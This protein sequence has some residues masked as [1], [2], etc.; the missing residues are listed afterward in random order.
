MS[1]LLLEVL[2]EEIPAKML[3][4]GTEALVQLVR[5]ELQ[6]VAG[7]AIGDITAYNS[8]RRIAVHCKDITISDRPVEV[9][10]PKINATVQAIEGFAKKYNTD[11]TQ[12]KIVNDTY[13]YS[14][15]LNAAEQ[16]LKIAQALQSV[17]EKFT[18][19]KSMRW[20][21]EIIRWVRPIRS[22]IC[23]MDGKVLP[24]QLGSIKAGNTTKGHM[25]MRNESFVVTDEAAYYALL[26]A[27]YVMADP[28]ERRDAIIA[29]VNKLTAG[30]GLKLRED[31]RLLEEV[32]NLV[33]WP[34]ALL[35]PIPTHFMQLPPEILILTI[36]EH[37]K[38]LLLETEDGSLAPYFIVVANVI[39]Q[40][41]GRS[42]L[43]G[44][45][46]VLQ[47]RLYDASFFYKQDQLIK[48]TDR[49]E[50]LKNIAYHAQIGS[51]FDK[52]VS[53]KR[54]CSELA[55]WFG[56]SPEVATR[57][58]FL[59]KADLTTN[60]VK[61]F[62]ELQGV[63]GYYYALLEGEPLE[64]AKA[65]GEHYKPRGPSDSLPTSNLGRLIS[66]ADKL[67]TIEQLFSINIKPTGSKDPFALRRCAIGVIRIIEAQGLD[68]DKVLSK[69][70]LRAD[71]RDFIL[72]RMK[73]M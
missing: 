50:Q 43:Q 52:I 19:P 54:L 58:C 63:M 68:L 7:A 29:Q 66:L 3:S 21:T 5:H 12:L 39:T 1:T 31:E 25:F 48:L 10:G 9:R 34:I 33:E 38:Y 37:Q 2:S 40:D 30:L 71:V 51:V 62:P 67:D 4:K 46:R 8:P 41:G 72:E 16:G 55:T 14:A 65:I 47:A 32:T 13:F 15:S 22:I 57:V 56:V 49:L 26:K 27:A 23:I 70:D 20:G 61:E 44:N 6:V 64:V 17:L 59:A 18:W 35:A 42:I 45:L 60:I 24:L 73:F 28:L 69:L 36:R 11:I 53:T